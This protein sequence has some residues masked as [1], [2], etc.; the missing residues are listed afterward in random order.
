MRGQDKTGQ[1]F[2]DLRVLGKDENRSFPGTLYVNVVCKCGVEKSVRYS[3]MRDGSTVS[4]G[5]RKKLH[6]LKHGH[7][8]IGKRTSEYCSWDAMIQRCNNPK[9][10]VYAAYGG[11]GIRVC[12]RWLI[13]ENFIHDMGLKPDS[14]MSI[15]RKDNSMGYYPENCTWAT[16]AQQMRNTRRTVKITIDGV[17]KC[18]TDWVKEFG[19]DRRTVLSRL[20]KGWAE[21]VAVLTP[22][23]IFI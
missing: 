11:R 7:N 13:F 16:Q 18:L 12:A 8:K 22:T 20:R 15:E 17:T 10:P 3:G 21:D 2:G 19:I 23:R 6:G 1:V 9:Y 4:C 5:C 14:K